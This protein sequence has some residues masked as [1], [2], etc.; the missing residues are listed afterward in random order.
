MAEPIASAADIKT[1]LAL[2]LEWDPPREVHTS[3]GRRRLFTGTPTPDFLRIAMRER[4]HFRAAGFSLSGERDEACWWTDPDEDLP[5]GMRIA[6]QPELSVEEMLDWSEPRIVNTRRGAREMRKAAPTEEFMALWSEPGAQRGLRKVGISCAPYE[7]RMEVTWW[8]KPDLDLDAAEMSKAVSG[9]GVGLI[10]PKGEAYLPF[11][12]AGIRY[13]MERKRV[14]LADEMGLGKT[15]QAIG[16]MNNAPDVRRALVIA[17]ASLA[18]NWQSEARK[19]RVDGAPARI[20]DR[21]TPIPD[22]PVTAIAT[23]SMLGKLKDRLKAEKWDLIVYDEAHYMKNERAQRTG[24]AL[25]LR[26]ERDLF[27]TGTP[28]LNRPVEMWPILHRIDPET[29]NSFYGFTR[30]YCAGHETKYG[31]NAKGASNMEDLQQRLRSTCMVR[32]LKADVLKELPPKRRQVIPLHSGGDIIEQVEAE[33]AKIDQGAMAELREALE[34]GDGFGSIRFEAISK[35]MQAIGASKAPLVGQE[36]ARLLESIPKVVIFARHHV[37]VDRIEDVL[38]ENGVN[39]IA[40]LTGRD[41]REARQ[42]AVDR[43]QNDPDCRVFIGTIGAAGVGLTLTA[44]SDVIFAELPWRPSDLSQAEDRTH[45]IGQECAVNVRHYVLNGSLD[46]HV[47]RLL[48]EKQEAIDRAMDAA[49]DWESAPAPDE[50][51]V[52]LPPARARRMAPEE[53]Q[54]M[55][56]ERIR[57]LRS[58]CDGVSSDDG[59]GFSLA[60]VGTGNALAAKDAWTLGELRHAAWVC[61][62]HKGQ[63]KAMGFAH[64]D[65]MAAVAQAA[66]PDARQAQSPAAA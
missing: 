50:V 11:Q 21:G 51:K 22:G 46:E 25:A 39:G 36:A 23:Y 3:K 17:P 57:A 34:R 60:T 18:L 45:R 38:R 64:D 24:A 42:A 63:L 47:V 13:C 19:W 2:M 55:G 29:W 52:A 53:V 31:W 10:A 9:D 12:E 62:I 15:I 30:A 40:R 58:C 7:G 20:V 44:A 8:R 61:A 4:K 56:L 26:S 49:V 54:A 1:T 43:F 16:L 48:V 41:G 14:L 6:E 35:A 32:R 65:F 5:E 37:V 33:I 59:M 27:M 66:S 28:I